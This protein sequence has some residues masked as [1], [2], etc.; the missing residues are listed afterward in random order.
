MADFE[1]FT[2]PW[3]DAYFEAINANAAYQEAGRKWE[4]PLALM[5]RANPA[6]DIPLDRGVL[7][8]LWHGNCRSA[9]AVDR[10]GAFQAADYVIEAD[11]NTW[12]EVLAGRLDPLKG[13]MFGKLKLKKGRLTALLP[14]TRAS[15][16]M[17][18]SATEVPTRL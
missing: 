4:G 13:L 3:A 12:K 10:D 11:T 2:Q 7:L 9:E 17:V 15:K 6:I 1:I 8:D 14:Y 18:R 5:V 16:E